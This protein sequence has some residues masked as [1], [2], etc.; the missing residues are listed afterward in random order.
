MSAL[1]TL[2]VCVFTL[3]LMGIC[4]KLVVLFIRSQSSDLA[5]GRCAN[6]RYNLRSLLKAASISPEVCALDGVEVLTDPVGQCWS[7]RLKSP[8]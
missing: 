7:T 5:A 1:Q 8:V 3:N 2:E 4:R 6:L